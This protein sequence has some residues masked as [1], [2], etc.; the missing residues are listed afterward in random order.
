MRNGNPL[1]PNMP[2]WWWVVFRLGAWRFPKRVREGWASAYV[3]AYVAWKEA[4]Y[5]E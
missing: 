4:G 2:L 5:P 1:K 3:A